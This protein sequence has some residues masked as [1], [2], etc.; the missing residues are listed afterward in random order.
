MSMLEAKL[1][2]SAKEILFKNKHP[3]NIIINLFSF[4]L[5]K[6]I[7]EIKEINKIERKSTKIWV[8]FHYYQE[9]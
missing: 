4:I 8:F 3:K 2:V 1:K 7:I 5:T 9:N 6:P